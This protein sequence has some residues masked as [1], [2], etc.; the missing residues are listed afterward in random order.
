MTIDP[1]E[2]LAL[3]ASF[4][5]RH[6][7]R[8]PWLA[9]DLHAVARLGLVQAARSFDPAAGRWAPH[10]WAWMRSVTNRLLDGEAPMGYRRPRRPGAPHV[11]TIPPTLHPAARDA[12]PWREAEEAFEA[13]L[14]RCRP[15]HAEVLRLYYRDGLTL[16]EIGAR[17]GI[18]KQAVHARHRLAIGL[19]RTT[20]LRRKGGRHGDDDEGA[21][22]DGGPHD[23]GAAALFRHPRAG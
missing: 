15:D 13:I 22:R 4:A 8:R 16:D 3:A 20:I 5:A 14:R 12:R 6:A 23:G 1:A 17:L 7:R 19:L 2:H 11:G 18:T 21:G 10:A 9:D